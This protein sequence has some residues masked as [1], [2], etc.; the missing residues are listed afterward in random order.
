M[1]TRLVTRLGVAVGAATLLLGVACTKT[2]DLRTESRTFQRD[3]ATSARVNV[4]MGAGKLRLEGSTDDL[5]KADF[6]YNVDKWKP[7]VDYAV[8]SG[9]G[10]LTIRQPDPTGIS[11]GANTTNE[12]DLRLNKEIPTDLT[13]DLGAGTSE[14]A[15]GGMALT[16]LTV[17]TGAGETLVDLTGAWD[18][19][20][21]AK[22]EGGAGELTVR[23]PRGVGARV[24]AETG[25]G[26]IEADGFTRQGGTWVNGAYGASPV[27]LHVVVEA[28]VGEVNLVLGD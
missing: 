6:R 13:V 4:E 12:W 5:T 3:E 16:A 23:L 14:L 26:T 17:H 8:T 18:Q 25:I 20:L 1:K 24:D 7:I 15:L 22:I 10:A 19:N 27:T 21:Q 11:F 2:N 9:V 28:G